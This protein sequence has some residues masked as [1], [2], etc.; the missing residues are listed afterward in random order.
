MTS[1]QRMS[2]HEVY[3]SRCKSDVSSATHRQSI[4]ILM[5]SLIQSKS[6]MLMARSLLFSFFSRVPTECLQPKKDVNGR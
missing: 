6:T 3:T 1:S 5:T 4:K 2:P